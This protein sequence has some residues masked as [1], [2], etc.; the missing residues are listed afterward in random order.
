VGSYGRLGSGAT[1]FLNALAEAAL[2]SSAAGTDVPK[3]AFI[4]GALRELGVTLCV[5]NEFVYRKG[6]HVYAAAGT[7]ARMGM[8]VPTADVTWFSFCFFLSW[9]SPETL[10]VDINPPLY[11]TRTLVTYVRMQVLLFNN[12][13]FYTSTF[14][15]IVSSREKSKQRM[16]QGGLTVSKQLP[17]SKTASTFFGP[18]LLQTSLLRQ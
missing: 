13:S 5:G 4:S 8:H 11:V 14:H 12:S 17:R 1:Q 3:A 6:L 15:L 16:T 7:R 2:A 10:H 18:S 9:I